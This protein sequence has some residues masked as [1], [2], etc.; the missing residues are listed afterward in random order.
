MEQSASTKVSSVTA[1]ANVKMDLMSLMML[2]VIAPESLAI[3]GKQ[4]M[5]AF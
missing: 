2:V 3:H 4:D 1:I 5:E